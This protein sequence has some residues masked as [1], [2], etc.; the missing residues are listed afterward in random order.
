VAVIDVAKLSVVATDGHWVQWHQDYRDP[1]SSLSRRLAVVRARLGEALDQARPGPV[2]VISMCAGEALDVVPVVTGHHRRPD[3]VARLVELDPTLAGL[4][5]ASA[6]QAGLAEVEVVHG[7][8]STTSAYA[9]AVPADVILICGVF[10]NIS[11][12]DVQT[13]I[14][15]VPHL[16]GPGATV[17]WTRH[18][19]SP[20][21]TPAIRAWFAEAGFEEV[22][23]DT[24]QESPFGV[25]TNRFT[26]RPLGFRPGRRLF[27]FVGDGAGARA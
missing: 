3:V 4:A 1:R 12:E 14:R 6:R 19:G 8:A 23:F 9:G 20:D 15:E 5:G 24:E 16:S 22:A 21:L 13:T 7:D 25:G 27:S 17:I 10:G 11:D 18:R 26:G 2:R